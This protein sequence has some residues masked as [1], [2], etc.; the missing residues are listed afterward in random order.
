LVSVLVLAGGCE[1][2]DSTHGSGGPTPS[3][4]PN[5]GST[6]AARS[7][8]PKRAAVR[9]RPTKYVG[10]TKTGL[11]AA[12]RKLVERAVGVF[13]DT[14]VR[15][16]GRHWVDAISVHAYYNPLAIERNKRG[17][18][19][20]A[21]Y[22]YEKYRWTATVEVQVKMAGNPTTF[23]DPVGVMGHTFH[24]R[25]GGGKRPGVVTKK[26]RAKQ[27]CGLPKGKG[28]ADTFRALPLAFIK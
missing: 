17:K 15:S 25:L 3:A 19:I 13:Y 23:S 6:A 8:G 1:S 24:Y 5:S 22:L 10:N 4:S 16:F 14:C 20:F 11:T 18:V 12:E 21:H 27:L 26:S 7:S 2:K 9:I 28:G